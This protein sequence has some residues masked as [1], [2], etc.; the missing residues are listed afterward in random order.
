MYDKCVYAQKQA[1]LKHN[2]TP[3]SSFSF[4]TPIIIVKAFATLCICNIITISPI[5]APFAAPFV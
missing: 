3:F 5:G 4:R 1:A 2:K